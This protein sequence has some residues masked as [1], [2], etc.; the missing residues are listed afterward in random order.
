[1]AKESAKVRFTSETEVLIV[2]AGATGLTL[3]LWL[4]K[5]G[6]P[7]RIVDSLPSAAPFSR[8][9]GVHARTLEFDRQLG[10]A[11][12]VVSGGVVMSAI[13]L[14][15]NRRKTAHLT[16]SDLGSDLTPYP[17][18]LDFAQDQ[19]ERLLIE[20]LESRGTTVERGTRLVA[21]DDRDDGLLATLECSD[22]T[23]DS[24]LASYVAGCDGAHSTVRS[25]TG[26]CFAGGSYERVFYVADVDASGPA[27]NGE[28]HVDLGE[29]DLL[30]VFAM[31]GESHVR[32]VG[33]VEG[34]AIPKDRTLSFDDVSR[35][36]IDQLG[37]DVRQVHWFSTYHVHHRVASAFRKG[38]AFLLGDAAHIHSPVGAQGMNTGIGDAVNLSWK[39]ASVLRG[40]RPDLLDTYGV[41]RMAFARRLVA[42]TDRAFTIAT[43]PGR[44]AAVVRTRVFPG[45]VGSLFRVAPFRRWLFRTISQIAIDYRTSAISVGRAG[46]VHGGDRLPWV[47]LDAHGADNF[48]SLQ[49]LDWQ[50]HVYGDADGQVTDACRRL[51]L[52]LSTFSWSPAA[53]RVGLARDATY[54]VRPDG[55][56]AMAAESG[57][58]TKLAEYFE[59][60][61]IRIT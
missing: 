41:E 29:S 22:G 31:K 10:F 59:S 17:F 25:A 15:V 32:L 2:G 61:G 51:G 34:D 45:V 47:E 23:M 60:R 56:V 20:Q 44:V 5:L 8:A 40:S 16:L 49:S 24:C 38:R 3:A 52:T 35:R 33:T 54:L 12:D 57:A 55:Y 28:L 43:K 37:L 4:Q 58:G 39:L 18:V 42:T 14:W 27:V 19:H 53:E 26:I 30:A 50:V 11:D 1:M 13:N 46:A 21:L 9:L 6:T 48:A 7:F 36:P